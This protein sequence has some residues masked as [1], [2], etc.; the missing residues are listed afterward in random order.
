MSPADA[1]VPGLPC[2]DMMSTQH[3][4]VEVLEIAIE[5]IHR[6]RTRHPI[7]Y[8]VTTRTDSVM[9]AQA[10]LDALRASGFAIVRN[11]ER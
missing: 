7:L 9:L 5:G 3:A 10:A 6:A 2:G 1:G 11:P 8:M 4:D